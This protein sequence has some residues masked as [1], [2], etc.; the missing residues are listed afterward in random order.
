V[1]GGDTNHYTIADLIEPLLPN[2]LLNR[3]NYTTY[4]F[5]KANL[6]LD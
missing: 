1:T 3:K 4:A 6:E 2:S 5:L